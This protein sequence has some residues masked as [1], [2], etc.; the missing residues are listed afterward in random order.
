MVGGGGGGVGGSCTLHSEQ[1]DTV[2]F[3][4]LQMVMS[5]RC[6][7]TELMLDILILASTHL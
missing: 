4:S 3:T 5:V 7:H 6:R 1:S 2:D